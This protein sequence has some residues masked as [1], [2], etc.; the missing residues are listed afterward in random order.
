MDDGPV[1]SGCGWEWD[2]N[3][4]EGDVKDGIRIS[5]CRDCGAEFIEDVDDE[6]ST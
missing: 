5:L 1:E 6:E 3:I 4:E 2:H